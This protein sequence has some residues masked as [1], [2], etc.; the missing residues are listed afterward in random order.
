MANEG[1]AL[2]GRQPDTQQ[3]IAF[4][5]AFPLA[6]RYVSV[7]FGRQPLWTGVAIS[8]VAFFWALVYLLRLAREHLG[9]EDRA[10]TAVV[11]LASYPFALFFSAAVQRGAVPPRRWWARSITSGATSCGPRRRGG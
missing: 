10:V 8:L 3:N 5:P 7:F 11:L 4:F 2:V 6:V 1:Y 9:D